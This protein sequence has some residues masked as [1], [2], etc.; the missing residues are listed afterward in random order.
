MPQVAFRPV[1]S[2]KAANYILP[3]CIQATVMQHNGE[4]NELIF[5]ATTTANQPFKVLWDS[6]YQNN[7]K[8]GSAQ[9]RRVEAA[10][11]VELGVAHVKFVQARDEMNSDNRVEGYQAAKKDCEEGAF[12][13]V[14]A[15]SLTN[16]VNVLRLH[17]NKPDA[18]WDGYLNGLTQFY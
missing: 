17:S 15:K 16:L 3:D 2:G 8:I 13:H 9:R 7:I 11:Q 4:Y 6:L 10:Y 1:H 5:C 12:R 18:F 14:S